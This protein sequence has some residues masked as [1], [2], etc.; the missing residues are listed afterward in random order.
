[1]LVR[2]LSNSIALT[3]NENILVILVT[4]ANIMVILVTHAGEEPIKQYSPHYE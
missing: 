3:M 4:Y 2:N 1:M